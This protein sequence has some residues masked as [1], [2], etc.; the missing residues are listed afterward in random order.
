VPA[1]IDHGTKYLAPIIQ[2]RLEE[3]NQYSPDRHQK[4]V[5]LLRCRYVI[6][7]VDLQN[8]FIS[9]YLQAATKE[10]KM[11]PDF[12]Q[13]VTLGVFLTALSGT[14]SSAT[15]GLHKI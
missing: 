3:E 9:W 13:H 14:L 11:H 1:H 2:E 5:R 7:T 8:D 4:P 6:L 15:V 10:Q 12:T